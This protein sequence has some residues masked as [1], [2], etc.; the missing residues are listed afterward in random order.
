MITVDKD[1]FIRGESSADYVSDRG[2]SPDSYGLN[3]T[4]TRG[5]LYFREASTDRGG[6]TLTGNI[7]ATLADPNGTAGSTTH[8]DDEGAFYT[9]IGGVLTKRQTIVGSSAD[10]LSFQLG[11]SDFKYF[12]GN[13]F[14]TANY[15]SA[16]GGDVVR[17]TAGDTLPAVDSQ[18]WTVTRSHSSTAASVRHPM[19][20]VEGTLYIG[21]DFNIHTW[22]NTTSTANAISLPN[23][24]NITSLIRHPD[25]R[26][27]LAFTGEDKDFSHIT[28][29]KGR[30]YYV[31]TVNKNW[32]R[33][34]K[35]S[36][37]VEGSCVVGGTI[38]VTY[39]P[40]IGYFNGEG[41]VF[42]K[43]MATSLTTYSQNM[44]AF[45][46]FFMV[47]DGLNVLFYGDLGAGNVW[48]K[49]YR[50]GTN[51]Q[52][53]NNIFYQGDNKLLVAFSDGAGAGVLEEI[54]YDNV[55][56]SGTFY[57]NRAALSQFSKIDEVEV[58]HTI[59]NS[60]GTSRFQLAEVTLNDAENT[61]A[62][63]N[64]SNQSTNKSQQQISLEADIFKFRVVPQNGSLGYSLFR[65]HDRPI[66]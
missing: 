61:F 20:I 39:G 1:N 54:D 30:V 46:D 43:K 13:L 65:F 44:G 56:T 19:E 36:A 27:L 48:W 49:P 64:Y 62:D 3:L 11:T 10:S 28:G 23:D 60:A 4:K 17:I 16:N 40:N 58:L 66:N 53:I 32:T 8:M 21:D 26:T 38:F 34:I 51:S 59:T 50:N 9:L 52:N 12:R 15:T 25:G 42:L 7:I 41:L 14:G 31:D 45:E 5:L 18:W 2:F 22:D 63:F 57:S 24:Q 33:E 37:Q 35:L 6:V 55:G 47:R 29:S